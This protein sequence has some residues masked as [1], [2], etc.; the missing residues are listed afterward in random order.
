MRFTRTL[1]FSKPILSYR[2]VARVSIEFA[3]QIQKSGD[4]C[5]AARQE[6]AQGW[7]SVFYTSGGRKFLYRNFRTTFERPTV[8]SCLSAKLQFRDSP[9]TE[10]FL[11]FLSLCSSHSLPRGLHQ[12][13]HKDDAERHRAR[14]LDEQRTV[15]SKA[16]CVALHERKRRVIQVAARNQRHQHRHK[17]RDDRRFEQSREQLGQCG[18]C[19]RRDKNAVTRLSYHCIASRYTPQFTAAPSMIVIRRLPEI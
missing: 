18:R 7:R 9:L 14:L 13:R 4:M 15:S 2:A 19:Q 6:A 10:R 11:Y 5:L 12:A 17:Q 16:C 3:M 1:S 8:R